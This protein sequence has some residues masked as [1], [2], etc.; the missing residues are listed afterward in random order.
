MTPRE[1]MDTAIRHGVP[2]RVPVAPDMSNMIPC[3]LTG[4]PFWD[5]YLHGDPPLWRAYLGAVDRF[6]I[7]GW[8]TYGRA[9]WKFENEYESDTEELSRTD[10]RI[11]TRTTTHTPHG[12]AVSE[13]TYYV[14][15]PPSPSKKP[16]TDIAGQIDMWL[17]MIQ[18]PIGCDPT[19]LEEQ[20]AALGE[21]G[22]LGIGV[23]NP[24]FHDWIYMV[25]GG[26]E[27]LTYAYVD[28]PGLLE[29]VREAEHSRAV[30][31]AEMAVELKPDFILT[32]G[33]GGIT[34]QSPDIWRHFA[35]P[36]LKEVCRIAKEAG[37]ATMVHCCGFESYLVKT[38]AEETDLD[39]VNPLE[40]PPMGDC[41]LAQLKRDFGGKLSLMGNLHT[42]DLMLKGSRD[43]VFEAS[44]K[45]IED[46]GEGGGFI[47]ST[48]DQ[49]GR[50]TPDENIFAMID[51][52]EEFGRY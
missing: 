44:R 50:D 30:K 41:D 25:Q 16:I 7:D 9:G 14:A 4:K 40:V 43:D 26:V 17:D 36:T 11:V 47:L 42:T 5:I 37:V 10:E 49:C 33:S 27:A 35:L 18:E 3:R 29:R 20:R 22:V 13:T 6:G 12:D 46:A 2:D 15:D 48:G 34:L 19:V 8:F 52:A 24:G 38:A 28:H 23:G 45:A 1:R 32:G 51:A 21:K 31:M 39:C